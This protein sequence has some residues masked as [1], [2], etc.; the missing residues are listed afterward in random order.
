ME[1][2]SNL[3]KTPL[4]EAHL[5]LGAQMAPFGGWLMPIQYE[6]IIAEHH[7][8]RTSVSIFDI[9]HMGEFLLEGDASGCG[10]DRIVTQNIVSMPIK[11]LRYGFMLSQAGGVIDDIIVYRLKENSW[12][13]VVNAATIK[14]DEDNLRANL[15]GKY[16]FSNVSYTLGKI[17][18][19]GPHS[20]KIMQALVGEKLNELSYYTCDDFTLL[21][22]N[23]IISRSGYTGE[24]GFEIYFP[25]N[26]IQEVWQILLK[27]KQVKPGGLGC[28]DTL[29]LEMSYPLYGHDI[30]ITRNP[31]QAGASRFVDFSKDFI[32]KSALLK[33]KEN[34]P[35]ET[36]I[37]LEAKSR[38]SPRQGFGIYHQDK[39]IGTVTS[40]SFSPSLGV[41]IAMGYISAKINIGEELLV[42]E[43]I[44]EIPSVVVKRPFYKK[45][46]AK[47]K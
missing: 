2:T 10:L 19:Q 31:L 7:H 43:G 39:R 21:G 6:G 14:A 38:R 36:L 46:T 32:G 16:S 18:V 23:V 42:K 34:G 12:M 44:I 4:Y 3:S 37:C 20:S 28:R 33:E 1:A 41:G 30:D 9:C 40:G 22:E 27:E 15:K 8:T 35:K 45:G 47:V 11:S 26:R 25:A 5:S 13:I 17:D 29:R 24:L